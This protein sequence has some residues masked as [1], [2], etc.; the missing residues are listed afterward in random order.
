MR[1]ILYGVWKG[2]K[3][4]NTQGGHAAP[5]DLPLDKINNFNPGNPIDALIS[6]FGFLVF[7]ESVSLAGILARYYSYVHE[8]SCG[9]C[10]PCRTGSI[11]IEMAL[12]D[13][14]AG[15]A[16]EVDWDH[17]LES[18]EQMEQT[19]LCG[20]GRTTAVAMIGALTFFKDRLLAPAKP[21]K[22]DMYLTMTAKCI[23]A[24]PAHVNIPR[25]IDYVRDGHPEL[26]A[27]VLLHHYPLVSTC[28]RVC[29]KPCEK[30]C[31]RNAVDA[32]VAIKEI[33]RYISDH[34][35]MPI[36]ELFK[37]MD[38]MTDYTKARVAV[39]GA[40]PA[41]L[42]CAYHL[43]MMG[44]PVDIFDKDRQAGGMALRG[45]PPYRLPKGVLQ[46][47]TDAIG[48]LGGVWHF[49]Q[50]L[51]RDFTVSSLFDD[52]YGAVFLGIGCAE[53]AYLGLP[54]ED[55]SMKGYR[56]GID[57]LLDIETKVADGILPRIDGD[58]VV[59]GCGNVAMDCC[60]TARRIATG[61]VHVVYRRTEQDAS[62]DPDEIEAAREEGIEFHF[63]TN[64]VSILSED[65][66]VT[67]V[68]LTRMRQTERDARGR[69]GVK[70]IEGSEYDVS[71]STLIA[72]I[73]QKVE[74]NVLSEADGVLLDRRGNISVNSA[75]ATSRPG[76][77][78]G[79]DCASG[80]TILIEGLAKGQMAANSI[81]EY[82]SRGSVG[83]TPRTRMGEIIHDCRLLDDGADYTLIL[84]RPRVETPHIPVS[85]RNN[86]R[87]VDLTISTEAAEHEAE[88]CM[89][90]YR[91]Y[92]V[93]TPRPIP[94]N[95]TDRL[96]RRKPETEM[97]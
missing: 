24:C 69:R 71:C 55:T 70:P 72:A 19:S 90:C 54:G 33:K 3:Y 84:K 49:G 64:P 85:E 29:V 25:Y 52:G 34:S 56:N 13:A 51:G 1:K 91:M 66:H 2:V 96:Y 4:D 39:V 50:R 44:Y 73:G 36:S 63:L 18:A 16:A 79:G 61:K 12:R 88:R 68:K 43:L 40:G 94:G 10:T 58:V 8:I 7:D 28:G 27:G 5:K 35:G 38:P 93:V 9:R 87:E 86:F 45:I 15:R 23:E 21:M 26:A 42:N 59:V 81:D 80:P 20:I 92:A 31:N 89:R 74:R 76:V 47:E 78:A 48:E 37:G 11:L 67:G 83:F 30:A 97:K 82:L 75:L 95:D 17:I 6:N 60:R 14:H 57:F 62:A 65:G 77:F 46:K 41:G 22:G 53:G 32:P